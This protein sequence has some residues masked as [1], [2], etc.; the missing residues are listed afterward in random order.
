MIVEIRHYTLRP[1]RREEFIAFFEAE[2]GPALRAAGMLVM[3]PF[4]DLED[5]DKVHWL[6]A[7]PSEA[8]RAAIKDDF[9]GGPVWNQRIEPIVMPMIVDYRFE[10][11]EATA[12]CEAFGGTAFGSAT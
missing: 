10:L 6:R 7:F 9:Y 1:G 11:A 4:R 2:N 8:A 3:G 12:G 5:A